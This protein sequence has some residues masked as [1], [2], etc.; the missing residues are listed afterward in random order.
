MKLR[1]SLC[2]LLPWTVSHADPRYTHNDFGIVGLMQTPTA[3]MLPAGEVAITANRVDPYSRYSFSLQPFDWMETSFRYTS[4]SNR[5]YGAED[6]SGD[7][8]YKDKAVDAKF[9]LLRESRWT[10]EVAAGFLDVGGTGLFSSEYFVGNKRFG[11]FDLSLGVAWGYLGNRGDFDN[12]LGWIDDKYDNRPIPTSDVANAGSFDLSNYYRGSP[13]LFGGVQWQTPWDRLSVKLEYDGNDYK[14]EPLSNNQDQSSPIN[15]GFVFK[16][17]D[18][19][20]LTAGWERGNT[21]MFGITLHTNFA[22]RTAPAKTYDPPAESLPAK[23]PDLHPDQ[24]DWANVSRRLEKNAG[25]KVER[26]AQRDSEIVVYGEQTRYLYPPKAVGRAARILDNSVDDD[27]KYFT[28]VDKRY[29]MPVVETSVPRETFRAVVQHERPLEDLRR[30]T[31]QNWPLPREEKEL[32]RQKP[33]PFSY[34]FGLGY[35]QNVGGP[36][37]FLLYQFTADAGAE[38]RFTPDTWW[39]GSLSA[40]LVNNFDKFKYDAPSNLP[41]VRTYL[42]EYWTTSDVTMTDFQ[43]NKAKRLDEDLYGMVYGGYL[44]SMFAGVGGELLYRPMGERWALGTDLNYVRQRDFDQGFGLRDYKVLTGH[45]TGYLKTDFQDVLAAVSVGRYLARDWGTTLDL[46]REFSNGVRF[47]GWVTLTTAS[48]EEYGEGSFDKG[49][50]VSIPFDELM[51]SSTMRRANLAWAPLTRDG[52]ARLS[53]S[54]SLYG[55]TDGRNLDMFDG[56][57][58]KITE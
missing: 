11:N 58:Q 54:Y 46:S 1:Y 50:Y 16:A 29:D 42:R 43:L 35:K 15:L 7:Q 5:R 20:D 32:F 45:V 23:T 49:I 34:G 25:Y 4:V 14:R 41:R 53:R 55:L 18:S 30:G 19:V 36:D 12:P 51:S 13:A 39:N 52:G 10:P 8:S 37:G 21:A 44:E 27:I 56:S 24:V 47:G 40:N 33:A 48:K 26:I 17:G 6:F 9:R 2:L 22:T 57:F 3:R 38:Y 31:E 28:V